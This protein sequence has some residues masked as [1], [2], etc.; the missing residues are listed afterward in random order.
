[1]Q[2]SLAEPL[3]ERFRRSLADLVDTPLS[4][5]RLG[6]AVSG[7]PDS[8]ALLLL[9]AAALPGQ[10][11]AAT[12]DHGFRAGAAAEAAE[13]AALCKALGV[14]HDSLTLDWTT[15]SAN[16]Q[17]L[18]REAR[19]DVLGR[20]A[21]ECGVGTL[22]TGHQL[23]DQVETLLM[24]LDRGAGAGGL[25]G[26]RPRRILVERG[27]NA[28]WLVRPLLGWRRAELN[29]ILD[30]LGVASLSDPSNADPAHDRTRLRALLETSPDWPNR[31]R[32]A[33]SAAYLREADEALDWVVK[34]L[35]E[36]RVRQ[37]GECWSLDVT[38]LPSELCLRM[39]RSLLE[40]LRPGH[41]LRGDR[42]ARALQ[43]LRSGR[44]ATLAGVVIRPEGQRWHFAKAPPRRS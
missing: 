13:V 36:D 1:M 23:D 10:V 19:Y 43:L 33:A 8:V 39:A 11:R 24:R 2:L 40:T 30:E 38:G 41:V 5:L 14:P 3:I 35:A 32:L 28:V 29:A 9:A 25:G 4:E 16:R 6:V 15:P 44:V 21:L 20:W 34:S 42:L 12:V 26:I 18:A 17:A 7:G 31:R 22:A 27:G 37:D